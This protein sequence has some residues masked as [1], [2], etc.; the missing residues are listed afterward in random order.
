MIFT[1]GSSLL[2]LAVFGGFL[3]N[4]YKN[5]G[6]SGLKKLTEDAK[7]LYLLLGLASL[8]ILAYIAFTFG[9]R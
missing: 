6:T 8:S 9:K 5:P 2:A 7:I 4:Q 3:L 1:V